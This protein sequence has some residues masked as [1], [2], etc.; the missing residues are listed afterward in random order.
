MQDFA[1]NLQNL[2]RHFLVGYIIHHTIANYII[3]FRNI[4]HVKC[5]LIMLNSLSYLPDHNGKIKGGPGMVQ[6][7]PLPCD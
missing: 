6:A 7:L 4:W 2:A 5:C 3:T 1:R